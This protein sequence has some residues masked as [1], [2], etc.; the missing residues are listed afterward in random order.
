MLAMSA[1]SIAAIQ[2]QGMRYAIGQKLVRPISDNVYLVE[3]KSRHTAWRMAAYIRDREDDKAISVLLDDFKGHGGKSG[4]I[5]R[6]TIHA[7][8][9]KAMIAK[10]IVEKELKNGS[11]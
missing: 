5:P 8:E 10:R 6:E 2:E 4:K 9:E 7:L 11:L 3:F 1:R